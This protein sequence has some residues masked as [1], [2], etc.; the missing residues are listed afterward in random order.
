MFAELPAAETGLVVEN[1]YADPEM[2]GKRFKE[3]SFGAI[4]TGIAVGDYDADGRPD[5]FVVS[6]TERARLFRNLGN[7]KFADVTDA[8]GLPSPEAS[9][10]V[11]MK[12]L[13]DR[14]AAAADTVEAWKQGAS[15]A[16]VNNDGRLDLYVC[17]FGAPNWLF[18]NQGD[19]T[20]KEEAAARGLAVSDASGIGAFCD[21][22]RDGALDVYIQTNML[23]GAT[24]PEGQ[25]DYLFR[26][27]GDGTFANVTERAGITGQNLAHSAT[28]W[29]YNMDGWPDLYVANDFAPA[30]KLYRNNRDGTFTDVIHQTVPYMPLSAM[31]ADLGD[32]N[33]DGLIDLLVGDMAATSHEKDHRGMAYLRKPTGTL[34]PERT[35]APQYSRNALFINTGTGHF[36]EAARLA[37]LA[38]SDWTWA[39]RLEDLDNDGRLDVFITNGMNREHNNEDIREQIYRTESPAERIRI[40]RAGPRQAERNLAF[41]NRGELDFENI[42]AAWG[43]D[44]MGVSFGA[45]MGDF[46]GDGDLDIVYSNY[47]EGVSLLRND[48]DTGHR[49]TIALKGTRSNRFGVGALV[50]VESASGIQVRQLVLA[51]GYLSTSEPVVHFG[52]GDDRKIQRLTIDWP[53][54]H[55]QV[56]E[57]LDPDRHYIATEPSAPAPDN[58]VELWTAPLPAFLR[59]DRDSLPEVV[60]HEG[61]SV[62]NKVQDFLPRRFDRLGPS[63]AVGDL[64]GSGREDLVMGGTTDAP[65]QILRNGAKQWIPLPRGADGVRS[66]L[67]D[68]PLLLFHADS[69]D[70]VDLLVTK[71]GSGLPA[72]SAEYQPLLLLGDGRGGFAP[73][74]AESLPALP[75]SAGVAV[76][77]DWNRDGTLDLFVGGRTL[78]GKYPLTPRSALLRNEGGKFLDVTDVVAP[79]IRDVGMVTAALWTDVD[80][81]GWVDLVVAIE[82]GGVRYFRNVD[83][84]RFDDRSQ[85][86]GFNLAGSGWWTSLATADFNGDGRLDYVAGNIGLNTQYRASG[87]HPA[88]LYYGRVQG[89]SSPQ[90]IEGHYEGDRLYPWRTLKDLGAKIPAVL[91]KFPRHNDYARA[92]L[93]EVFGRDRLEAAQRFAATELRSGVFMSQGSTGFSFAPL[94]RL[95]QIAPAQGMVAGDFDGDGH[96]D[97][98]VV[99][100]SFAPPPEVGQFGGGVSQF[101][102]GNGKGDFTIVAPAQSGLVVP[103]DAKALVTLDLDQDGWADF[104]ASRNDDKSAA[105]RNRPRPGRNSFRVELVGTAGN[106]KAIGSRITLTLTDGATQTAEVLAGSG[107]YSQSSPSCF[108]GFEAANTPASMKVRWPS[109]TESSHAI[110]ISSGTMIV[111]EPRK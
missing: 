107:Y 22:D 13:V 11:R 40:M 80:A 68:G 33:N 10:S 19:G 48:S 110:V 101:L 69:D 42:G 44:Q 5:I 43:L 9:W 73:S 96:A 57:G 74:P 18:I 53:S 94:P 47:E 108:F 15:F 50:R 67:D 6:K 31:G 29:D 25:R 100:N 78:P 81:D 79:A 41:R 54:G 3:F 8:A 55:H 37:G 104:F 16:D 95:A 66:K 39:V 24:R 77:A 58:A 34:G 28:W 87:E 20:F 75:V 49:V 89:S 1:R 46:D 14:A 109:G 63:V 12:S 102:Q 90:L 56:F 7:F 106:P 64:T 111:H 60:A 103:G 71:A 45:A 51:R 59:L 32:V 83:G 36:L 52:L 76:A 86:A 2:W 92:T 27:N 82:W 4:G 35:S 93:A 30:D 98:Y 84:E 85:A 17:R 38:A 26:N 97:L 61:A 23:D 62:D 91:K 99:Q 70:H 65:P 72:G 88:L 21:F 105:F